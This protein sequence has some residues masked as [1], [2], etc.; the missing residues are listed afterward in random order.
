MRRRA[1]GVAVV[2]STTWPITAR[3]QQIAPRSRMVKIG[4]LW[5]AD[6]ADEIVQIYG[7]AL[8]KS[9]NGLGYV[10]GKTVQFIQ[11]FSAE[12]VQ[13]REFAKELVEQAPDVIVA[14]S[15]FGAVALKQATTTIPIV[16]VT[17]PNPVRTGLVGSLAHPGGNITGL[18]LMVDDITGKRLGFFKEAVPTLRRVALLADPKGSNFASDLSSNSDSAK[19]LGI[20]L[21]LVEISSPDAIEQTFSA[22]AKDGFDGAV[23]VGILALL[24]RARIGASALSVKVPTISYGAE[25]V[26][27]GL[28]MSY[29]IDFADLF[30]RAAG[31]ADKILKGAKPADL[32]IERPTRFKLAINLKVAKALGL[33]MPPLLLAAADEVIE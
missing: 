22:I 4:I 25:C 26:P 6:R 10:E 13:L 7:D 29:G 8:T 31:Y 1:F 19:A 18:S 11:R 14:A 28:L 5:H 23:I 21:H 33:T 12:P 2:L 16:V 9:L 17:A 20:D 24:E 32:P 30:R 15:E 27:Y 3:A